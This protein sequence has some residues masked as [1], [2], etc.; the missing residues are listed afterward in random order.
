MIG[1]RKRFYTIH[2]LINTMNIR[3]RVQALKEE[4]NA[5]ILAH[6]YCSNEVQDIADH[7]GDSLGLSIK[8]SEVDEPVIVFCGV[9]FMAES[10]KILNPDKK[11]I[12]P[13]EDAVCPMA[14]MC[15]GAQ[16]DELR[17]REPGVKIIGYV[18]TSAESKARM[19]ICCTSANAVK[20]VE[21]MAGGDLLFVP[22]RNLGR[23]AAS[24]AGVEMRLWDGF[25]PTHQ[26]ITLGMVED[27]K[28]EHPDAVVMAHPECRPEVLEAS[29]HIG[30]T[31]QMLDFAHGS[32]AKEFIVL[33]EQGLLHPL[34]SNNPLKTFY[35]PEAALCP[36]MKMTDIRSVLRALEE[37]GPEVVLDEDTIDRAR[38]PLERMIALR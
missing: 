34:R 31:S 36:V 37:M 26:A 9:T 11:V 21:S 19:D 13:E 38:G 20:V 27:L 24:E 16:L 28:Q 30:S 23:H 8:A 25:C 3:Q 18:N 22:D 12:I 32:E 6:N 1:R 35:T 29:D 17:S 2:P 33:T 14:N 15:T 5:V 4:R 10:A 7:T